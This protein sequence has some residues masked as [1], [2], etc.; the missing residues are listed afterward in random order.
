MIPAALFVIHRGF[1]EY[2]NNITIF[3]GKKKN[4]LL[5]YLLDLTYIRSVQ[6]SFK[7]WIAR[8]NTTSRNITVKTYSASFTGFLGTNMSSS[9]DYLPCYSYYDTNSHQ[10]ASCYLVNSIA[11]L[12]EN[13]RQKKLPDKIGLQK[14]IKKLQTCA[15]I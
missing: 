11:S 1:L 8:R 4:H 10:K 5:T 12:Q 3:P 15:Q 14:A 7:I 9:T 2:K 6:V 13:C